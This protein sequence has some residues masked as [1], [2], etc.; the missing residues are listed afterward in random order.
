MALGMGQRK[1]IAS[2]VPVWSACLVAAIPGVASSLVA[3]CMDSS[4]GMAVRVEGSLGMAVDSLGMAVGNIEM[5]VV[6]V[7]VVGACTYLVG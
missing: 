3:A 5:V 4:H 2:Q 6:V 1:K 7:L